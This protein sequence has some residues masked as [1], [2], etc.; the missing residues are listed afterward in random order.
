MSHRSKDGYYYS[1]L[2]IANTCLRKYKYQFIDELPIHQEPSPDLEFGTAMH[3]A[4]YSA[5]NG[6]DAQVVFKLCWDAQ[7]GK[8]LKY[9][10][11]NHEQLEDIGRTLLD[12][13]VRFQLKHFEPSVME[14]RMF[15]TTPDGIKIEG[16]ADVIGQYKGI[17][18]IVDFKTSAYRYLP[19]QLTVSDQLYLYAWLADKCLGYKAQQIVYMVFQKSTLQIQTIIKPLTRDKLADMVDNILV[20]CRRLSQ[21]TEFPANRLGCLKGQYRCPFWNTCYGKEKDDES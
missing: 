1:K 8:H 11:F 19:S 14:Q 18:S 17:P 10:R 20:Q 16:T 5:L 13:F 7:K 9:G 15:Y 4:L 2:S 21:E 12:K 6:R 3:M